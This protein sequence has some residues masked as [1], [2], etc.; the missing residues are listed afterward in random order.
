[1][2]KLQLFEFRFDS[3]SSFLRFSVSTSEKGRDERLFFVEKQNTFQLTNE[4]SDNRLG[5]R[6]S[7]VCSLKTE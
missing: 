2:F 6:S 4:K 5:Y 3:I 1:M 7:D